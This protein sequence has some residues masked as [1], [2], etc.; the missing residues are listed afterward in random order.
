[1]KKNNDDAKLYASYWIKR[2]LGEYLP[3]VR[4]LARNTITSYRD[5]MKQMMRHISLQLK[6]SPDGILLEA[7]SS[8]LIKSFL[9]FIEQERKCSIKTRNL[10]LAAIHSLADYVSSM[11]PEFL[12]W[13]RTVHTVPSKKALKTTI[14][15]LEKYEM[16]ALL[17]A[18]NRK[19]VFGNRDYLLLLFL[20][21]TGARVE[22]AAN[23]RIM[24]ITFPDRRNKGIAIV[25]IVGKGNK[26]RR[27]PLWDN[28]MILLKKYVE[29]RSEQE[30]VFLNRYGEPL[31]RFGIYELVKKYAKAIETQYPS[32][33]NKRLSPHTLRHTTASHLLQSGVD[34]N[35][36]RAWLGHVSIN[37]TNIYAEINLE[38]KIQALKSCSIDSDEKSENK[39][40]EPA[41][42]SA[43]KDLMN[44]LD[45][46]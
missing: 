11:A 35:T 27:C 2:Y 3:C 38:M 45:S 42:W 1:M 37:T 9:Q 18:P 39:S 7:I 4:N 20:Y 22:E 14:P 19:S 41:G 43:D 36:I 23:L 24:D 30:N 29:G 26:L 16:D 31:T 5:T 33:R 28:T 8:D 44:F 17:A 13:C 46:L 6:C 25:T 21:N 15:Y 40:E 34:I 32:I 10:R 12:E